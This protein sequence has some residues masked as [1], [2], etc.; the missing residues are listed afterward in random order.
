MALN[1]EYR[2]LV[3]QPPELKVVDNAREVILTT[4]SCMC[5]NVEPL[6]F[7]KNGAGDFKLSGMGFALSN[8]QFKYPVYE[9]EWVAD[10]GNWSKVFAMINSGTSAIKE[11]RSR[12]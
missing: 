1:N 5:D 10:E 2:K 12:V 3:N 11:V 9:I 7:K 4:I 6:R 8:W